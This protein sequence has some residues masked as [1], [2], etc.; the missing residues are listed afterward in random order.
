MHRSFVQLLG[1]TAGNIFKVPSPKTDISPVLENQMGKSME[2]ETANWDKREWFI[3]IGV[4]QHYGSIFEGPHIR[5][6]IV[7]WSLS[8]CAR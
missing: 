8:I 6:I 4:S 3:G 5:R 2:S 1:R 7:Y